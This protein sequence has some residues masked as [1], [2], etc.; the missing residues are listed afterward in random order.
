MEVRLLDALCQ[1]LVCWHM[2][3]VVGLFGRGAGEHASTPY[4]QPEVRYNMKEKD[5]AEEE[6][7][8]QEMLTTGHLSRS[9]FKVT[10]LTTNR[11]HEALIRSAMKRRSGSKPLGQ[12]GSDVREQIAAVQASSKHFYLH[13]LLR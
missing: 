6:E 5:E 3:C 1:L 9:T 12:V 11:G 13:V 2:R 8:E 7:E 4:P 10:Q